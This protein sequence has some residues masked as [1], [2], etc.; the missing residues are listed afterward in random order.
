MTSLVIES[1]AQ[2]GARRMRWFTELEVLK[3]DADGTMCC[4]VGY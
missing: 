1:G 4:E 2:K 3:D